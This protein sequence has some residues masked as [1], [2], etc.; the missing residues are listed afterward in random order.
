MASTRENVRGVNEAIGELE[1][2]I[3]PVAHQ[4]FSIIQKSVAEIGSAVQ[5]MDSNVDRIASAAVRLG[6]A[7]SELTASTAPATNKV[8]ARAKTAKKRQRV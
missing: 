2:A 5:L 3:V 6:V 1:K 7:N 4:V 8:K